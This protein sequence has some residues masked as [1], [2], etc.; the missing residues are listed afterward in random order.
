MHSYINDCTL[1]VRTCVDLFDKLIQ[2]VALYGSEVWAPFC[3]NLNNALSTKDTL[4]SKFTDFPGF[5]TQIKFDKRLLKVHDKAVNLAVLGELGHFPTILPILCNIVNFWV[6]ILQSPE[7][8]FLYDAYLCSYQNFFKNNSCNKW[9]QL[10][11][12]LSKSYPMLNPLWDNQS[13]RYLD[14]SSTQKILRCFKHTIYADFKTFWH[15]QISRYVSSNPSGGR[16]KIFS[17]V[18]SEF[19]YEGY[20]HKIT[21]QKSR[22]SF[23]RLRI[24]AHRLAVETGRHN[25]VP[26]EKR[27]CI[28][29]TSRSIEDEVHFLLDCTKYSEKRTIFFNYINSKCPG[30]CNFSSTQKICFLLS[31]LETCHRTANFIQAILEER[32]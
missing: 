25:K 11:K 26:R 30:F 29:C 7:D 18:K 32:D 27:L 14:Y 5:S 28:S 20:L 13:A 1:P 3:L 6:H 10:V 23:T 17:V 8:S 9:F 22:E 19:G 15:D 16:L 12:F 4:F 21:S 31:N 24:S 2:P